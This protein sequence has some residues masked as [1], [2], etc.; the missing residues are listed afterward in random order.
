VTLNLLTSPML[1][2]R[3]VH[4]ETKHMLGTIVANYERLARRAEERLRGGKPDDC[5]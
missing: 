4:A 2:E 3:N 1:A 5:D